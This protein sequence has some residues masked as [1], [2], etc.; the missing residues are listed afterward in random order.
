V[1]FR[2]VWE[3]ASAGDKP[4]TVASGDF[5]ASGL[6]WDGKSEGSLAAA[7]SQAV[8]GLAGEIAGALK[9]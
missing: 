9:K 7:I 4:A 5:R 6:R 1:A 2:A 3:L 8:A